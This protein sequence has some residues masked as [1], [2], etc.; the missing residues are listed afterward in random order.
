MVRKPVVKAHRAG[1]TLDISD[2]ETAAERRFD[3]LVEQ[4]MSRVPPVSPRGQGTTWV[5]RRVQAFDMSSA[6]I[7]QL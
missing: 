4:A 1:G 6:F 7:K 3:A 5:D 2:A